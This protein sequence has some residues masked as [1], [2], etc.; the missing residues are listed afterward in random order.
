MGDT[1][2]EPAA[3]HFRKWDIMSRPVTG[4]RD[5][6]LHDERKGDELRDH[7]AATL[8]HELRSPLTSI[9]IGLQAIR[10]GG[11][12]EAAALQACDVV[13]RQARHMARIIDGVLDLSRAGRDRLALRSERVD[14]AAVVTD[15]V[16]VARPS[17]SSRGH[18]LT[19]S[20]PRR[21][22][23]LVADPSRLVQILTNLLTNAA[24]YTDPGGEI[25]LTAEA[26]GGEVVLRVR[27]NGMGIAPGLL[28]RIFDPFS[29]GGRTGNGACGGLGIGL[30]LV[31]SLVELHGGSV[32]AYS[33]GPGTGSEFVVRLPAGAPAVAQAPVPGGLAAVFSA[34]VLL[35]P[36]IGPAGGR[37]WQVLL[38]AAV[39]AV[40]ALFGFVWLR[41]THSTRRWKAALDLYAAREAVRGRRRKDPPL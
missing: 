6:M 40:V 41:R 32:T 25:V 13:E 22:V 39:T 34:G 28:R 33:R 21:P 3:G 37:G 10:D 19:V 31:K 12:E 2:G 4:T 9:L 29:Q 35:G 7:L 1:R 14:L 26:A 17:L 15:A 27:D 24:R 38:A 20:L 8:A 23:L 11:V 30:A 5:R 16:E 18:R 36:W